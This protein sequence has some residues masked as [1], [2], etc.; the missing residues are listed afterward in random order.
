VGVPRHLRRFAA[1]A[2]SLLSFAAAG[3]AGA[4]SC[5][6]YAT[7]FSAF[8]GPP[9]LVDGELRV[10]WCLNGATVASSG[11]CPTGSALKLDSGTD[12]P[13]VLISTGALGCTA[14]EISFSYAQFAAT[15]TTVRIGTTNATTAS[16]TAST[17]TTVGAL[18]ATGGVCTPFSATV[19]L[20]GA[21]GIYLRLDH[22]A[23][24][25]ALLIDDLVIRR[26]GCCSATH[27]CCETGGP[28]CSDSAVS[29]CV[30]AQD[31]YCC[32][33]EW[34]AQCVA[35]VDSLGCG[36]C[37]EGPSCLDALALDFG[38]LYSGGSICSKFPAVFERCEGTAPFLTSSLGCASTADMAMRFA[39]GFPYSAAVTRC[40]SFA[41]RQNPALR[42][43]YAKETGT[44]GPRVE[45]S[46]DGATWIAGWTAPVA[47]DGTCAEVTLDLAPI[48]GEAAVWFRFSSGSSIANLA[49]FDDIALV[50]LDVTPHPCCEAGAPGCE[51][52]A[53]SGCTCAIDPFCCEKAWDEVC[54][55]L[56]TIYCD[57]ACKGLPVCGS[58]TAGDCRAPHATPACADADCCVAVCDYDL[59]CCETEWDALCVKEAGQLCALAGDLDGNGRVDASDL[60]AFLAAW[61]GQGGAADLDGDG[62]V[63]AGDLAILLA[64]WSP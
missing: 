9:D 4:Q 21:K 41:A 5:A 10:L 23:N 20:N 59:Y 57:A 55:M 28:G 46:L 53:I 64:N 43:R 6:V 60:A 48:A 3:A 30:C 62:I 8:S 51:N 14:I 31:P 27:G 35:E 2:A 38:T 42:F 18:T 45:V 22:G 1:F 34:D 49:T 52:K 40:V 37:V 19:P 16:C 47:F 50:E 33:T 13:V 15:S 7:D 44:L 54:V 36:T 56:A 24:T 61:G 32:S 12:D 11:F 39:Q 58:P 25:N 17:A 63:G 26:V 29:A